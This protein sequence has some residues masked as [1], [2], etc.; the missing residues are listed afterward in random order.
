MTLEDALAALAQDDVLKGL[1]GGTFIDTF[2]TMKADEVE[3][4]KAAADDPE[5]REVTEW[6]V[7]EYLLDY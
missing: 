5:T 1:L 3:R 6:E 7:E 2:V 4:Y